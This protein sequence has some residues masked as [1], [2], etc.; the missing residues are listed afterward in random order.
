M[1]CLDAKDCFRIFREK[2]DY[3][4]VDS[5]KYYLY[6]SDTKVDMLYQQVPKR[7]LQK[8]ASELNINLKLVAAEISVTSK[9]GLSEETR[10]S[11]L[12]IVTKYLEEHEDIGTI[13]NLG[14]G[15]YF[16]GTLPMKWGLVE[17]AS[18]L[19][20]FGGS[21]AK[22]HVGLGGSTHHLIGNLAA[23]HSEIRLAPS[24]LPF[25][26]AVLRKNP[27]SPIQVTEDRLLGDIEWMIIE[28]MERIGISQNVEFLAVK[29]VF[30]GVQYI[31]YHGPETTQSWV[32]LGSPIYV[33]LAK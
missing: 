30:G 19:V 13:D 8:I 25:L 16:K 27:Q 21:T 29:Y 2:E 22:T 31:Q 4:M 12:K 5:L 3:A 20:F 28:E 6:V 17:W 9:S 7:L 18:E 24:T 33:A 26:K 10:Y 23:S 1:M 14:Y 15:S 11:K 32:V